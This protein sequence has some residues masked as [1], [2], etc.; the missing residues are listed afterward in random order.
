MVYIRAARDVKLLRA[1]CES[2]RAGNGRVSEEQ[3]LRSQIVTLKN[4]LFKV[5][6]CDLERS[7]EPVVNATR[8]VDV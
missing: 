5:A 4:R 7:P 8:S 6:I 2:R 1:G 3:V